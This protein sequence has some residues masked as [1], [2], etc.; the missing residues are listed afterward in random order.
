MVDI[1]RSR[2]RDLGVSGL[3]E[4][5]EGDMKREKNPRGAGDAGGGDWSM[6]LESQLLPSLAV[7]AVRV[8]PEKVDLVE[9]D[10]SHAARVAG[11]TGQVSAED[12][13][14]FA[15]TTYYAR[16]LELTSRS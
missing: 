6:L 15:I 9:F 4:G 8:V 1:S 12:S 3:E 14:S 5:F 10:L 11:S 16:E 2:P 7:L 13:V